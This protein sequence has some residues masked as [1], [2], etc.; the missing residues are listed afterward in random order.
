M[1]FANLKNN[2]GLVGVKHLQEEL[3]KLNKKTD[4][5]SGDDRFWK[6]SVDKSGV[7]AAVIR[8]LPESEGD[9]TPWVVIYEHA[10]QGPGGW[11]IE[12]SR[13]SLN[14]SVDPV[15]EYN[16][17][18][19]NSGVDANKDLARK[20]KRNAR[21]ISNILVVKDPANPENEGKVFLF[22]YG[23]K[24]FQK[25]KESMMPEHD[26]VD[27]KDPLNP[28]CF[29]KGANFKLKCRKVEGYPNYD[30]SDFS[31]PEPLF[32]GDEKKLENLWKSQYKLS[33]LL[34][35]GEFKSYDELKRKLDR[36]LGLSSSNK[37]EQSSSPKV[38]VKTSITETAEDVGNV[39]KSFS[40]DDEDMSDDLSYLQQ[41]ASED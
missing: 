1:S 36:V 16:T 12:K 33:A 37:V 18:L 25:I 14:G 22:K 28:F 8:F 31:T 10:F 29:W 13:T 17:Q 6:L 9:S 38:S 27:Q 5:A 23:K 20:Q 40:S 11:Y 3:E 21:Y 2:Q 32:G 19:W 34:E 24:I 35:P 30:H 4:G 41:L 15:S 39:S 7:G 26:P